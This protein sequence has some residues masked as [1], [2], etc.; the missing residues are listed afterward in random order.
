M[1]VEEL[2][3]VVR[4][5]VA[6][7]RKSLAKE[8]SFL[9]ELEAR[10]PPTEPE[11]QRPT[12]KSEDAVPPTPTPVAASGLRRLPRQAKT[13]I[14]LRY[15]D[16]RPGLWSTKQMRAAL[17]ADGIDPEAGTPVK[18]ILWHIAK[19]GRGH[20]VGHGEYDFPAEHRNGAGR[21]QEDLRL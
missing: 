2:V 21:T 20:S 9:A 7:L 8:E 3:G 13:E 18:N 11:P 1:D 5:N 12:P 15:I 17:T 4:R 6:E 19:D 14:A 16:A 10:L